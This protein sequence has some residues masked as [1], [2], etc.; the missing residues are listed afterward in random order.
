MAKELKAP[1]LMNYAMFC[2]EAL[3]EAMSRNA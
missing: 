3:N 2:G 1:E